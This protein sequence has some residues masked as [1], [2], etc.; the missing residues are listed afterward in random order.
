MAKTTTARVLDVRE[1]CE[2]VRLITVDF[3]ERLLY[4]PGSHVDFHL[5]L[6]GRQATRSYSL[7]GNARGGTTAMIAVR[8]VADSRGGSAHMWTLGAGAELAVSPPKNG[9]PLGQRPVARLLVAGG[10]GITPLIGMAE[11]LLADGMPFRFLYAGRSRKSM[12]FLDELRVR[13]GERLVIFDAS[14]GEIPAFAHVLADFAADG[15]MYVCGPIG[16]LNAARDAWIAGG[17]RLADLRFE[18]FAAGGDLPNKPFQVSV[19]RLGVCVDVAPDTTILQ[20]LEVAGV[21]PLF[22]CRK[23]ECGLCIAEVQHAGGAVDHRDV[24]LSKHQQ[25]EN[26][27]ICICVSRLSEGRLVL[28]L[29]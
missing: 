24:F 10:I 1:V 4:E 25:Q 16:M 6:P 2:D 14:R 21:D 15:E 8:K 26:K 29:P 20:A 12:P 17:R 7:I 27:Q 3:G 9:F 19:P 22:N 5:P 13:L 18:T 28:D 23:G 11:R